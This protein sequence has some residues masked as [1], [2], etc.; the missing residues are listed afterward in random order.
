MV[1]FTSAVRG[2]IQIGKDVW[3]SFATSGGCYIQG[4]NGIRIGDDTIFAPGVKI[5]SANH[6]FDNFNSWSKESPVVIG[7]HCWIGANAVILPGVVLGDNVVVA[8]G[9]VVTKSFPE[10]SMVAGVPARLLASAAKRRLRVSESMGPGVQPT[11]SCPPKKVLFVHHHHSY[12]GSSTSMLTLIR[13]LDP[14]R[15]AASVLLVGPDAEPLLSAIRA[16]GIP[17]GHLPAT[18]I[19]DWPCYALAGLYDM[20]WRKLAYVRSRVWR[21]FRS[22]PQIAEYLRAERPDIVHINE[23]SP[24]SVAVT[25]HELGIPVVW[26]CRHILAATRPFLDPGRRVIRAMTHLAQ[27][28]VCI[29]ESEA[30]QFPASKVEVIYNPLDFAKTDQARG[31]GPAARRALGIGATDYVV[32]A[33]IPL[34]TSKGAWDFIRACGIAAKL[35]PEIP[36]RFLVVGHLPSV[37][38]RHLLRKWTGFLGPRPGLDRA[39]DLARRA[40]IEGRLQ[41]TG[42]RNDIYEIMDGS[43]LIVFP[44]HLRACGRPCFEAGALKKPILVTMPDK[45]T[46]IVLDGKTGRILPEK[47][48]ESLGRAIADL[49]RDRAAGIRMGEQGFEHVRHHFDPEKHAGKIMAVYDRVVSHGTAVNV[50]TF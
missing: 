47:D 23:V 18:L 50:A 45:N 11:S 9:A 13:H 12:D 15:Y 10:G 6:D 4:N 34:Y 21:A 46:G 30:G 39:G 49:A 7:R 14:A 43:D 20:P 29:S 31:G 28:V 3:M 40:G 2:D 44:S 24:V 36:M 19:G 25:A 48:P 35:A 32:T 26:H 16:L 37:G 5:I 33:P 17:A 27:T 1:H 42:F 22:D 8:A 38:R 41:F